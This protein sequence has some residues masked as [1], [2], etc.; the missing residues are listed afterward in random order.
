MADDAPSH[1]LD[2]TWR[3]RL[4]FIVLSGL[5]LVALGVR[6]VVQTGWF[7]GRPQVI[8]ALPDADFRVDL[9]TATWQQLYWLPGVGES[10]AREI[11]AYREEHGPFASPEDLAKVPHIGPAL[12]EKLRPF[13]VVN[14]KP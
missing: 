1:I 10:I 2:L 5:L 13:V 12:V 6:Y 4:V 11:V 7:A 14:P 9:N 3:E 8:E